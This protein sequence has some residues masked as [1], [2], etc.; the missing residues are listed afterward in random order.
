MIPLPN[1]E[2]PADAH[3]DNQLWVMTV[4]GEARGEPR[5]GKI[6]VAWVIK[7]RAESV[8]PR[9]GASITRVCLKPYQFSCWNPKDPNRTKMLNPLKHDTQAAWNACVEVVE[10]VRDGRIPDPTH[11]ATHYFEQ[12]LLPEWAK[13]KATVLIGHQ[14]FV[15]EKVA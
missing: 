9:F 10:G 13:G 14:R 15:T 8:P 3:T 5:Q 12:S 11:G 7:N 4:W 1:P 2:L 6:A